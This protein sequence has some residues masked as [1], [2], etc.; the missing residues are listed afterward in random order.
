MRGEEDFRA[1]RAHRLAD[2]PVARLA[3]RLLAPMRCSL[4][5]LAE[6]FDTAV[7]PSHRALDDA[8]ATGE[9]LLLLL[10][11]ASFIPTLAG[12]MFV[13]VYGVF[14]VGETMYAPV[15]NPLTASL[16][17]G[18]LV[19]FC[20]ASNILSRGADPFK[21]AGAGANSTSEAVELTR[22]LEAN[23]LISRAGVE[24]QRNAL[25]EAAADAM[26]FDGVRPET[27]VM[28]VES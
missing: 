1:V 28:L 9:I 24:L 22:Y 17:L 15:L 12:A 8:L 2:Q 7:K 6:R 25:S 14:A 13:M 5:A 26:K 10:A 11:A 16:A 3:R 4:A 20:L 21:M 23:A 18:G 27:I 19:G